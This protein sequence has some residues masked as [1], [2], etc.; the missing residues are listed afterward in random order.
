[1]MPMNRGSLAVLDEQ[2]VTLLT[3]RGI[4]SYGVGHFFMLYESLLPYYFT[5]H[6]QCADTDCTRPTR[7]IHHD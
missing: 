7:G 6:H 1:M 5:P 4:F 3:L 2:G